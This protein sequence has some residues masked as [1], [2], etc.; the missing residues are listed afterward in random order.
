M[1]TYLLINLV[2]AAWFG[3]MCG[4]LGPSPSIVYPLF[5]VL[6]IAM[7]CAVYRESKESKPI[8]AKSNK[9]KKTK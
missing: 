6:V 4:I 2:L 3:T 5:A 9:R 8:K 1:K 7:N